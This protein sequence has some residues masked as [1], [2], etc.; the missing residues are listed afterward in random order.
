MMKLIA[1]TYSP[2]SEAGELNL[3]VIPEY[4]KFLRHNKISGVFINGSTGDFVSL[5]TQ[6]RRE[7][8]N[9]WSRNR[10]DNFYLINHVGHTNLREAV[11]LAA[12]SVGKADAIAAL[13]PYYFTPKT[14]D[15]LLEYCTQ[16]AGAAPELPFYY[17]HIPVL[18]GVDMDMLEFSKRALQEIPNFAGLKFTED[19]LEKFDAVRAFAGDTFEV[20]FGVDERFHSSLQ[21]GATCWVGSTY[22]HLAP[23]Y[24]KIAELKEAGL[25]EEAANLQQKAVRFVEILAGFGGFPGASK[26]FMRQLGQDMGASRFPHKTLL[27][28]ELKQVLEQFEPLGILPYLSETQP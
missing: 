15:S 26:S 28:S 23:A 22:N 8:L 3:N 16:I 2:M 27:D 6:E 13:A 1:A 25:H 11:A 19:N 12:D 21:A 24:Y 10:V 7:I 9:A 20:Y 14:L 5:S 4:S 18:T 17:Y